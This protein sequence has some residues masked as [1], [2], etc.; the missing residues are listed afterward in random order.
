MK[1]LE[2]E[3]RMKE[4]AADG[5]YTGAAEL[6]EELGSL[7][8]SEGWQRPPSSSTDKGS[9]KSVPLGAGKGSGKVVSPGVEHA[10]PKALCIADLYNSNVPIP[11]NVKLEGVR[12]LCVGKLSTVMSKGGSKGKGSEKGKGK[13]KSKVKG[14]GKVKDSTREDVRVVYL[15][16]GHGHVICTAAFGP[17]V[18]RMPPT[19]PEGLMDVKNLCPR[20]GQTG[21]LHWGDRTVV[22]RCSAENALQDLGS[23]PEDFFHDTS[24][25]AQNLATCA[26]IQQSTIGQL[27]D[28]VFYVQSFEDKWQE[29]NDQ[30]YVV[31][32]GV[33][34]DGVQTGAMRLWR[35]EAGE[36]EQ[37]KIYIGRGLKVV[38]STYWKGGQYAPRDDGS[39]TVECGWRTALEDVSH[40]L[41]IAQYFS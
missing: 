20:P 16:Q 28:L 31:V 13:D 36:V 11:T 27:V 12:F 23:Q 41:D 2:V 10:C 40:V 32:Y 4:M 26:F 15:G 5:D 8:E 6:Q 24:A 37:S 25:V 38:A 7:R 9:G 18:S 34:M 29:K 1:A 14:N 35:Y 17:I 3:K 39:K 33:D 22:S 30:P 21:I 19:L